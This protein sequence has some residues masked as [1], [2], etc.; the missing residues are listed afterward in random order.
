MLAESL[1]LHDAGGRGRSATVI[2]LMDVDVAAASREAIVLSKAEM[3]MFT[4]TASTATS[5]AATVTATTSSSTTGTPHTLE[6]VTIPA[7][8][9]NGRVLAITKVSCGS[10][11]GHVCGGRSCAVFVA[12]SSVVMW[13]ARGAG[14][15]REPRRARFARKDG[16][17]WK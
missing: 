10:S 3:V 4:T 1:P 12:T 11:V 2:V 14:K 8:A 13:L 5:T 6:S 7:L 16:R 9:R 15:S 17:S